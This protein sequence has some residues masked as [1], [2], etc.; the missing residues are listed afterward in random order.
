VKNKIIRHRYI[1]RMDREPRDQTFWG[2]KMEVLFR[3]FSKED[4]F[5]VESEIR[6]LICRRKQD[7]LR[8]GKLREIVI[9]RLDTLAFKDEVL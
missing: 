9:E 5:A 2:V 8:S 3:G 7:I 4:M 6:D 1:T